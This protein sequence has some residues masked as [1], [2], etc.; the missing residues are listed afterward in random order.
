[1]LAGLGAEPVLVRR[2]DQLHDLDAL[3]VPGGESTAIARL[4]ARVDLL[5]AVRARV[6]SG[7][8]VL[9][10]CAGLIL[11]ADRVIDAGALEGF[12]RIAG[13]DVTVR[14]NG[15]GG[16]LASFEADVLLES[17][18]DADPMRV[19]FIR[20]PIIE[21]VGADAQ[22]LAVHEERPVAVRQGR[23]I[24]AAFHPE[25][26]GDDRLHRMLLGSI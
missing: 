24:A 17:A 23:V 16:Q 14:R 15:Y 4:A 18:A 13:L 10:T 26:T 22:V 20:A 6:D 8:P 12:D 25:V 1:M 19:A 9:G 21:E 2:A 5:P 3:V 7:M 11:L